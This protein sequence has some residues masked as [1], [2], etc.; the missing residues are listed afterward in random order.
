MSNH[1]SMTS[2][3]F[4]VLALSASCLGCQ[5]RTVAVPA[6][7]TLA[8]A[9][10]QNGPGSQPEPAKIAEPFKPLTDAELAEGWISLFDGQSLFG[11]KAH[12]KAVWSI[13]E[14]AVGVSSGE[15]GLLCTTVPFDNYVLKVDF[16]AAKGT[17]SGV[18]LRTAP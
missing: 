1:P 15:K 10:P 17:N 14:G 12:S 5:S 4:L 7:A 8:A 6:T 11:W 18:F 9:A 16:R 13:K 3:T 2:R